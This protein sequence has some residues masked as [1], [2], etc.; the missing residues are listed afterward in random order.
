M[1]YVSKYNSRDVK[2]SL[3]ASGI[4]TGELSIRVLIQI[5]R[6][7]IVI[8]YMYIF[9]GKYSDICWSHSNVI[10]KRSYRIYQAT[11]R[12]FLK[13]KQIYVNELLIIL[14][15]FFES[16]I[17][18]S[19]IRPHQIQY[20]SIFF[21]RSSFNTEPNSC[22][23]LFFKITLPTRS[24]S[25]LSPLK[26]TTILK[27]VSILVSRLAVWLVGIQSNDVLNNAPCTQR[28]NY[29]ISGGEMR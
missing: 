15:P 17:F 18:L 13:S 1:F 5:L 29:I 8:N 24:T 21:S 4:S 28:D 7:S 22:R 2:F 27:F 26:D 14:N 9:C 3:P 12:K 23:F 19:N 6:W 25:S 11:Q 20:S 16:T 10:I